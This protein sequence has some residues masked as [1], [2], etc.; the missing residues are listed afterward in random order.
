MGIAGAPEQGSTEGPN[1]AASYRSDPVAE[2]RR[3]L[4]GGRDLLVE[5]RQLLSESRLA[6]DR[7]PE[8]VTRIGVAP[9]KRRRK[10]GRLRALAM[11]PAATGLVLLGVAA[12]QLTGS[13][14]QHSLSVALNQAP[15][16]VP[17]PTTLPAGVSASS[18]LRVPAPPPISVAVPRLGTTASVVGEAHVQTSGPEKG[19]LTAPPNY[20]DLGWFR[21]DDRGILVLDGHV[22]Y[23]NDPGPLAFIGRLQR[24]DTVVVATKL[25]RQSYQVEAV[26]DAPKGGLPPEYFTAAYDSDVMLI[27][28][29]YNSPFSDGHFADNVYVIATPTP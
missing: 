4:D 6:V 29:D 3:I 25:G 5:V 14:D 11:V 17:E 24:G 22:G 13:P 8:P 23:R 2:A 1:S 20:R 26:A 9:P 7:V 21:Q 10:S 27:T 19:L 12:S 16:P 15:A 28:C 18:T